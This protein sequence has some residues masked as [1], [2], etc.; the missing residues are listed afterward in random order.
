MW[1]CAVVTNGILNSVIN[2][3]VLFLGLSL[4]RIII[5]DAGLLVLREKNMIFMIYILRAV[6]CHGAPTAF[7]C[8]PGSQP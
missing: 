3:I 8:R 6:K 5:D 7:R 1:S 2:V 4:S